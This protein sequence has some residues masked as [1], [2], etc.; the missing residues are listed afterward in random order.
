[1]RYGSKIAIFHTP[2]IEA[3][4]PV[5]GAPSEFHK[6]FSTGKTRM[7]ELTYAEKSTM[8]YVKPF[9][10]RNVTDGRTDGMTDRIAINMWRQCVD[11]R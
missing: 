10:Y 9:R 4:A 2:A 11:A 8:I 3:P 5:R 7:I 6:V 1:M